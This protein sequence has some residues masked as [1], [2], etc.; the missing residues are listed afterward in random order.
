MASK[1]QK[2]KTGNSQAMVAM[3]VI[4][5]L[6]RLKQEDCKFKVS[7]GYIVRPYLSKRLET[8]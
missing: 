8:V 3:P 2:K 1:G 5:A 6:R 7:L 4:L